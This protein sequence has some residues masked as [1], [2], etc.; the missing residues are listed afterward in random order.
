[1]PA[2]EG[3]GQWSGKIVAH[4]W[5]TPPPPRVSILPQ[6]YVL[7]PK[8]SSSS[9]ACNCPITQIVGVRN[10]YKKVHILEVASHI[11]TRNLCL[12]PLS[13]RYL[14]SPPM[15]KSTCRNSTCSQKS[16]SAWT[17]LPPTPC[18]EKVHLPIIALHYNQESQ[19]K[20]HKEIDQYQHE[21]AALQSSYAQK[22]A[23]LNKKHKLAVQDWEEERQELVERIDDLERMQTNHNSTDTGTYGC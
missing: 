20:L 10:I 8:H 14:A 16:L 4:W 21:Q 22:I 15:D 2:L 23:N 11:I 12:T 7:P 3:L 17:P 6:V 1:M 19:D 5:C 13:P 18:G 9:P